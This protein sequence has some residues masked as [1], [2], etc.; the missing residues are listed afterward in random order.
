MTQ[1][2]KADIEESLDAIEDFEAQIA[3]LAAEKAEALEET[4][5]RW[6]EVVNQVSEIPV[7]PYKKDIYID[8]FGVAWMPYHLVQ[9]GGRVV[10]LRGYGAT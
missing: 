1:Q 3:E 9:V 10:Q 7:Q 5:D 6:A 8:L 2:A 4:R